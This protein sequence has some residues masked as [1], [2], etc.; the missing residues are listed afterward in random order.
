MNR[1]NYAQVTRDTM[2][3]IEQTNDL[4]SLESEAI[5]GIAQTEQAI[6]DVQVL[7][8]RETKLHNIEYAENEAELTICQHDLDVFSVI[9]KFT[10]CKDATATL[11]QTAARLCETQS[12]RTTLLYSDESRYNQT[13]KN[14]TSTHPQAS[15]GL[16]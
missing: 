4:E 13:R 9:V 8:G 14:F 2:R 3:L 11:V 1:I 5:K 12:G 16:K 15:H 10:K 6:G 7:I